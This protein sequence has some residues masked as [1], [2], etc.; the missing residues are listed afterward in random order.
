MV[1]KIVNNNNILGG[2]AWY[3]F[4]SNGDCHSLI[5]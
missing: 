5:N 3:V 2:I 4:I 1:K